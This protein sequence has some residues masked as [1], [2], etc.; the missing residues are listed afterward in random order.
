MDI[1]FT[2]LDWRV[3]EDYVSLVEVAAAGGNISKAHTHNQ[4]NGRI[5]QYP[6]ITFKQSEL[7]HNKAF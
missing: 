5:S 7:I 1:I 2:C 6:S 4:S 3:I